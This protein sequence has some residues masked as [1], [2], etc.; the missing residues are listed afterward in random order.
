MHNAKI[1][2]ILYLYHNIIHVRIKLSGR[3]YIGIILCLILS[4]LLSILSFPGCN[5]NIVESPDGASPEQP[6]NAGTSLQSLSDYL[7]KAD[8]A[9]DDLEN[10]TWQGIDNMGYWEIQEAGYCCQDPILCDKNDRTDIYSEKSVWVPIITWLPNRERMVPVRK[11]I[12]SSRATLN[13]IK[14]GSAVNST[15]E[16]QHDLFLNLD[17]SLKSAIY[18][19]STID[20]TS[21]FNEIIKLLEESDSATQ[22]RYRDKFIEQSEKY[23]LILNTLTVNLEQSSTI[24]LNIMPEKAGAGSR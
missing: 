23:S 5:N 12:D 4:V 6:E 7:I 13:D 14:S 17:S 10:F 8:S 1:P 18:M 19:A 20:K 16:A 22:Q 21:N 24:I 3:K 11:L 2:Q 15:P 9:C